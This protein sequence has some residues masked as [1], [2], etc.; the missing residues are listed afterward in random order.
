MVIFKILKE[1]IAED[2]SISARD[3][4]DQD[5]DGYGYMKRVYGIEH[6]PDI[7]TIAKVSITDTLTKAYNRFAFEPFLQEEINRVN[8]YRYK[9]SLVI[10]CIDYFKRI[11][12]EYGSFIGDMIL[13]E[14]A[15]IIKG[16][17]RRTDML[18]RWNGDE[19]LVILPHTDVSGATQMVNN[20]KK[21]IEEFEFNSVKGVSC[22]VGIVEFNGN[23][24]TA[25]LIQKLENELNISKLARSQL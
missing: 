12:Y 17:I 9:L 20:I 1:L 25:K 14:F 8:R 13:I 6:M 19:F 10:L 7:S 21:I 2:N 22:S 4:L 23:D 5:F 18:F 24:S 16:S 3:S 15:N 11:N